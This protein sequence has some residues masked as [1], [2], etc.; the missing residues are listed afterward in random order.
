MSLLR[1]C[2]TIKKQPIVTF[3][4]F[5]KQKSTI[6]YSIFPKLDEKDVEEQF[7]Q[8]H[9][10]GGS[11]VNKSTNCVLLKH[12]PTGIV[13]KCHESRL[14]QENQK[15]AR[16]RLL[17]KLDEHYNNDMSVAAQKR[18]IEKAKQISRQLK[19]QKLRLLKKNFLES[20]SKN[21]S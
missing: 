14:L 8:G 6:D 18:R 12:K 21:K 15:I 2:Y 4:S 11:N 9:G 20:N 5:Y 3:L 17:N 7:I 1:Y 10:P 16:E 19:S 13:V